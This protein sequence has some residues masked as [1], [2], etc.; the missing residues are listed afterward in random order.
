MTIREALRMKIY[1]LKLTCWDPTQFLEIEPAMMASFWGNKA[2][3][4]DNGSRMPVR[5]Q[6]IDWVG[7][8][9][10]A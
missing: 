2:W 6:D 5:L 8:W 1:K 3:I 9:V 10:R 7:E 4:H